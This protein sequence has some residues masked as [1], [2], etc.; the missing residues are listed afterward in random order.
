MS[1]ARF[2]REH[3]GLTGTKISC[4]AG[5]C[6]ACTVTA[7]VKEKN[8]HEE[9]REVVKSVNA[10]KGWTI[11]RSYDMHPPAFNCCSVLRPC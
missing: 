9:E 5:G 3:L 8:I 6:G 1:L 7:K 4:A 11:Q 10:V 2:L